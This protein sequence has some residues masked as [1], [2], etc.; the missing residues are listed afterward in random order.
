MLAQ[1]LTQ[2]GVDSATQDAI[3]QV[4]LVQN[5]TSVGSIGAGKFPDVLTDSALST[6]DQ[7][8][9]LA[10]TTFAG[11]SLDTLPPTTTATVTAGKLG[12]SGYYTS[13]VTVTLS[14]A[15]DNG[16]S[17]VKQ[18][19]YNTSGAQATP[20]TTVPGSSAQVIVTT[21][22]QTTVT[23]FAT[24][25]AGNVESPRRSSSRSI[26]QRR[27]PQRAPIG[28]RMPPGGTTGP[29]SPSYWPPPTTSPVSQRLNSTWMVRA[30]RHTPRQSA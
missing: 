17:G 23:V 26:K 16:G 30:G 5:A 20:S 4:L 22:G 10:L 24:D 27:S 29:A 8:T 3:R 19:T 28:H 12:T 6:T 25:N 21:E 1:D 13:D 14:A 11:T 18:I 2:L 15:D 9:A 7:Q